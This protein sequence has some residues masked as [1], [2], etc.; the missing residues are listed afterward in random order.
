MGKNSGNRNGVCRYI[1]ALA[2]S[3][4]YSLDSQKCHKCQITLILGNQK[5]HVNWKLP[6]WGPRG[7]EETWGHF[8][9]VKSKVFY[10]KFILWKHVGNYRSTKI[11]YILPI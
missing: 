4:M 9:L 6:F 2:Y 8:K 7:T 3:T 5:Y 11:T 1:R 10:Q